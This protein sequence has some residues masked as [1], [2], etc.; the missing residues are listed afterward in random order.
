[1]SNGHPAAVPKTVL[2]VDDDDA[3]RD[4]I[5][6]LLELDGYAILTAGDGDA[7]LRLLAGA[8]RPCV[9]LIDLVMPRVDGWELMQAISGDAALRDITIVC[10]T[11]GR[12]EPPPGCHFV[13]RK[14]F[15]ETELARVVRA[16]FARSSA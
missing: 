5:A 13:L 16:A 4:A 11:A 6:D 8:P 12:D 14:P 9:A 7:A 10:T 1:M 3:V 15:D 2:V